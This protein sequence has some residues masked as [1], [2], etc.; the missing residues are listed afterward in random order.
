[1]KIAPEHCSNAVLK[2]MGK[3]DIN[4]LVAFRTLFTSLN[5]QEKQKLFLTYYIIAAHPGCTRNDMEQLKKFSQQVLKIIPRQIQVFTPT[6][7]TWSTL[8]YWTEKNPWTGKACFVEKK[9]HSKRATKDD[10]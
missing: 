8:M 5:K 2:A 9:H 6:P 3:P 7:S 1:M 4:S 10:F